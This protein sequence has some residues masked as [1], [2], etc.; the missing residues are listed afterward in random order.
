V[1]LLC[2]YEKEGGEEQK[3]EEEKG[4]LVPLRISSGRTKYTSMN[5]YPWHSKKFHPSGE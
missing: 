3:K 1:V 5:V 4:E 2:L